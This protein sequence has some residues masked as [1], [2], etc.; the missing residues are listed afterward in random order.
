M[1]I[2]VEVQAS[3]QKPLYVVCFVRVVQLVS[4]ECAFAPVFFFGCDTERYRT[5][6]QRTDNWPQDLGFLSSRRVE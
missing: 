2:E 3:S 4:N 6:K 5:N 1:R